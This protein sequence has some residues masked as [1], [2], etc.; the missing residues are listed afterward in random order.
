MPSKGV[1]SPAQV[2]EYLVPGAFSA[3]VRDVG[4]VGAVSMTEHP[5]TGLPT[6]FVHPCRTQDAM[7]DV[8]TDLKADDEKYLVLWLGLVGGAVGLNVPTELALK[9]CIGS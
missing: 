6:F 5:V 7:R 2:Y 3:Q 8:L 9:Q 1:P 4:V